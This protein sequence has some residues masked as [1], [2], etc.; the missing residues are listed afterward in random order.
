MRGAT[1]LRNMADF[2]LLI[3]DRGL[4]NPL[5]LFRHIGDVLQ[6]QMRQQMIGNFDMT[7]RFD[8]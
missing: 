1:W 6:I 8:S 2:I 7:V 4:N 3:I 5:M